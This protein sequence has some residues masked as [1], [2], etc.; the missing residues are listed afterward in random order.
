MTDTTGTPALD[1][2]TGLNLD[3][4]GPLLWEALRKYN[5]SQGQPLV[6]SWRVE[7]RHVLLYVSQEAASLRTALEREDMTDVQL[8]VELE[9]MISDLTGLRNAILPSSREEG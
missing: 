2:G 4:M 5:L 1:G 6:R 9:G 3:L 7:A 8:A